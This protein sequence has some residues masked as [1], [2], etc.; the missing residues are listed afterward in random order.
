MNDEWKYNN[1]KPASHIDLYTCQCA[2]IYIWYTC[3]CVK[4]N[5]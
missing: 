1:S 3:V 5:T 2:N 4:E